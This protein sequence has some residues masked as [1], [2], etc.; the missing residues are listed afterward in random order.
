LK[1]ILLS[2]TFLKKTLM[3]IGVFLLFYTT[4][5]HAQWREPTEK[6]WVAS[7]GPSA[8]H[9][10][11]YRPSGPWAIHLVEFDLRH[12][13]LQLETVKAGDH[14][15]GKER[16]SLMAARRDRER[17]RI[18]AAING[19]FYDTANGIPIN[20]QIHNGQILRQPTPRSTFA[21]NAAEKPLIN[22]LSLTGSLQA[23]Q[24]FWQPLHGF[25]RSRQTDELIFF[26]HYFGGSTGTNHF[27]S[28]IRILPLEKFSVN[29]TIRAVVREIRRH[30]G[31]APLD[32]STYIISGHGASENWLDRNISTGD[33]IKFVWRIPETPW[34]LVEAIGGL[35]RL[36][37]DGRISVESF[38]EGGS[39]SFTN[40]RHPRSAIGF[41]ADTSRFFFVTVDGR[42]SGYS[43][44]MTLPELA[45]FMRELGCAQALNL[46]GGGS[47]T[48]V[49]R[50]SVVNRPSDATGERAVANAL[51]LICSA[52]PGKLA[53]IN[54][55]AKTVILRPAEKFDFNITAVDDFYNPFNLSDE[56]VS[57][58]LTKKLGKIDRRGLFIAGAKADS[59]YVI[60]H[61]QQARDSAKVVIR[62]FP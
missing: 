33:T 45:N 40:T 23:K 26:N 39:T 6:N 10:S 42:Q 47:T 18:V 35:P 51:L 3:K 25:N 48:M 46:D 7:I 41:N 36:V 31:N 24:K 8:W 54:I 2:P 17:H 52:P 4:F 1:F 27:G 15:H 59:G 50:G 60:A 62:I 29:D 12:P 28:E 32:D 22:F 20:L 13:F 44:G 11:I 55:S 61:R 5:T 56:K 21:I 53:N 34:Q 58:A 57:W 38:L 9:R 30:A 49:V 43:E 37:R 19:D 16:T 14:L